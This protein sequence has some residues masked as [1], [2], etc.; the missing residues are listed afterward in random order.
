MWKYEKAT[1]PV[2]EKNFT[3]TD[4]IVVC[5]D[6]GTP[7][8]RGCY[9]AL[10]GCANENRH[11]G[12]YEWRLPEE[13]AV[14]ELLTREQ[15]AIAVETADGFTYKDS[16]MD[17]AEFTAHLLHKVQELVEKAHSESDS[18]DRDILGVSE[19]EIVHFQ[20]RV[21]PPMLQRFRAIAGGRRV[22]F[23]IFAGILLP[24][25]QFFY[26]MRFFGIVFCVVEML[27]NLPVVL[28]YLGNLGLIG[29]GMTDS[30]GGTNL[31]TLFGML[32]YSLMILTFLFYDYIY[33]HWMTGK[34]KTIRS[35]FENDS[36]AIDKEQREGYLMALRSAGRPSAAIMLLDSFVCTGALLFVILMVFSR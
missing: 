10:H 36:G 15:R 28:A 9:T 7:H 19:S 30:V 29:A 5:P 1:C 32:H 27:S 16:T 8:H 34:I 3:E 4:D 23:N 14:H 35:R 11:A 31:G 26:R 20:G 6:C 22:S 33:L 2:C 12:G 17:D 13:N 25:Y 24:Y 21:N 18:E